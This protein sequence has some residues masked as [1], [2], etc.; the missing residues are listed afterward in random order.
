MLP[1]R[2]ETG[3]FDLSGP[4][5]HIILP[6]VWEE[7]VQPGWT[8]TMSLRKVLKP[9]PVPAK[10]SAA[11]RE[12]PVVIENPV[13][14]SQAANASIYDLLRRNEE[15]ASRERSKSAPPAQTTVEG[16][17]G[18]R[19]APKIN[20]E[21]ANRPE[22]MENRVKFAETAMAT[23]TSPLGA[24]SKN[25]APNP[26]RSPTTGSKVQEIRDSAKDRREDQR[27]TD[28]PTKARKPPRLPKIIVG[29]GEILNTQKPRNKP[30]EVSKAPS[31]PA[32]DVADAHTA[33]S[34]VKRIKDVA[35]KLETNKAADGKHSDRDPKSPSPTRRPSPVQKQPMTPIEPPSN[36]LQQPR[37]K[38]QEKS[39]SRSAK[40]AEGDKT[41][42][43]KE[44]SSTRESGANR[45]R[46]RAHSVPPPSASAPKK[47]SDDQER[48]KKTQKTLKVT[49]EKNRN[50]SSGRR[51]ASDSGMVDKM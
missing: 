4:D 8:V 15:K 47:G 18:Q 1:R 12:E 21:A 2:V 19:Q 44:A 16:K 10:S 45:D 17:S 35:A 11:L 24:R 40:P 50:K 41:K 9:T 14:R 30:V 42:A 26:D 3:D 13:W 31:S 49:V 48:G 46:E 20:Q 33:S 38:K 43:Y 22:K 39:K 25:S 34:K 6:S 51:R 27:S 5:G 36:E 29:D 37:A 23:R 32:R 28:T 7:L